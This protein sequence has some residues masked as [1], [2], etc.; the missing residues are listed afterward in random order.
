MKPIIYSFPKPIIYGFESTIRSFLDGYAH[1]LK[2][3]DFMD[4]LVKEW[5]HGDSNYHECIWELYESLGGETDCDED[6]VIVDYD[7]ELY[8]IAEKLVLKKYLHEDIAW[9]D[10]YWQKYLSEDGYPYFI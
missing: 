7:L 6:A 3:D 2:K 10:D 8:E 5:I 4:W 1:G 9:Q